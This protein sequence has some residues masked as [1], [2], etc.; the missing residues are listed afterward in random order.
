MSKQ[1]KVLSSLCPG[2]VT[3]DGGLWKTSV[4]RVFLSEDLDDKEPD[5][6]RT[7]QAERVESLWFSK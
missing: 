7:F 2:L 4:A 1:V 3:V 5:W 6:K